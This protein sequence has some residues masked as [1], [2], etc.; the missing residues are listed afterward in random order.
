MAVSVDDRAVNR[1]MGLMLGIAWSPAEKVRS[2][3]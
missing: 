3:C 2:K 1:E